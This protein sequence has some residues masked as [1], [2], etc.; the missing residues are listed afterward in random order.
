MRDTEIIVALD[1]IC[2]KALPENGKVIS[3]EL[4]IPDD[5]EG[6]DVQSN[7]AFDMDL[8]MLTQCSG[9]KE[10]SRAEYE[11]LA[12]NSG[13]AKCKFVCQAYHWWGH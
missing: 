12:A 5:V 13:F 1:K 4:V 10:R 3:M 8:L 9:G 2:W 7:I 11:A 6:A